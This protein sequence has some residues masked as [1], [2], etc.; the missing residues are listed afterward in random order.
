MLRESDLVSDSRPRSSPPPRPRSRSPP[1]RGCVAR[2]ARPPIRRSAIDPAAGP[3]CAARLPRPSN[4]SERAYPLRGYRRRRR[5]ILAV[6]RIDILDYLNRLLNIISAAEDRLPGRAPPRAP[7]PA[8]PCPSAGQPGIGPPILL[9]Q[10]TIPENDRPARKR[11]AAPSPRSL[12]DDLDLHLR[13]ALTLGDR[14]A[15]IPDPT[16]PFYA[17]L[18]ARDRLI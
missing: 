9:L 4:R 17:I 5:E 2:G 11:R 13:G 7:H 12:L 8:D 18:P 14:V 6:D 15:S 1:P 3:S 16:S 10:L